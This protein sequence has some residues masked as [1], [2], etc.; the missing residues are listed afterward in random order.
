VS[1]TLVYCYDAVAVATMPADAEFIGAYIDGWSPTLATVRAQFPNVP[2][3]HIATFTTGSTAGAHVCDCENGD[4]TPASAAQW[5]HEEILAGRSPTIYVEVE[6]FRAVEQALGDYGLAF[7][8]GPGQ[9]KCWSA[10]WNGVAELVTTSPVD[11]KPMAG[12]IGKQFEMV[13]RFTYDISVVLLSWWNLPAPPKFTPM[14]DDVYFSSTGSGSEQLYHGGIAL[15]PTTGKPELVAVALDQGSAET[16]QNYA[17]AVV[18]AGGVSPIMVDEN[19]GT[20]NR[21]VLGDAT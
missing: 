5:A 17:A 7:G 15:N 13:S 11:G 18:K 6:N 4:D 9:V 21:Y 10:Y 14:E 3:D 19:Q 16:V 1:D 20:Y 8:L 2:V 12:Q